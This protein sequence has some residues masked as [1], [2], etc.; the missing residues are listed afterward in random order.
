MFDGLFMNFEGKT[1]INILQLKQKEIS[2]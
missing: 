1:Q 2:L